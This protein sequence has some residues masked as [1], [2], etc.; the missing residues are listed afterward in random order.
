MSQP[1]N[2]LPCRI[3][4]SIWLMMNMVIWGRNRAGLNR[5]KELRKTS[6]NRVSLWF[7]LPPLLLCFAEKNTWAPIV[8]PVLVPR[9]CPP[10]SASPFP[11]LSLARRKRCSLLDQPCLLFLGR[12]RPASWTSASVLVLVP[13]LLPSF[14][15]RKLSSF[16]W[17]LTGPVF[18]QSRNVA[19]LIEVLWAGNYKAQLGMI[20]TKRMGDFLLR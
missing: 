8:C 18:Y 14:I 4:S 5:N 11:V 19:I 10:S 16:F 17:H 1:W 12:E 7:L 3:S 13:V 2:P 20:Y 6:R 9:W 15:C